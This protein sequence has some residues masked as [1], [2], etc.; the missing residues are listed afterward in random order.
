MF[1]TQGEYNFVFPVLGINVT[2]SFA[3]YGENTFLLRHEVCSFG[4]RHVNRTITLGS[5]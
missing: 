3:E 1:S 5:S 2:S 4:V